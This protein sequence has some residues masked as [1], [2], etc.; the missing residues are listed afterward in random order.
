MGL[1]R[2]GAGLLGR[3]RTKSRGLISFAWIGERACHWTL[4]FTLSVL[5]F[6]SLPCLPR[7][8]FL[9]VAKAWNY[10]LLL[11]HLASVLGTP[12]PFLLFP[13][14]YKS[15]SLLLLGISTFASQ[16]QL[17]LFEYKHLCYAPAMDTVVHIWQC[18]NSDRQAETFAFFF[19]CGRYTVGSAETSGGFFLWK[20]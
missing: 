18:R 13:C 1:V 17:W 8:S 6:P 9:W 19:I 20:H 2:F 3:Q 5:S 11:H 15:C 7:P 14:L 12:H 10:L 16:I 4:Q